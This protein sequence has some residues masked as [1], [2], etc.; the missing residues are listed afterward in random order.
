MLSDGS[1]EIAEAL[2]SCE[3]SCE[4]RRIQCFPC[5]KVNETGPFT[6]LRLQH[7][8]CR[9]GGSAAGGVGVGGRQSCRASSPTAP[10]HRWAT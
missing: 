6:P 5:A 3:G 1:D 4:Q 10:T 8:G 9:A 7:V 2:A